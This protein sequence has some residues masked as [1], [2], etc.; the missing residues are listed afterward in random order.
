MRRSIWG[1]MVDMIEEAISTR[2]M[3]ASIVTRDICPSEC[4]RLNY[5]RPCLSH[6]SA[7]LFRCD[8]P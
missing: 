7:E 8:K 5:V 6:V 2:D 4:V 1:S 3:R